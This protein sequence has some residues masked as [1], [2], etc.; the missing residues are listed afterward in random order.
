MF[1]KPTIW[2]SIYTSLH[3]LSSL[4]A[5]CLIPPCCHFC[6]VAP[7]CCPSQLH[8]RTLLPLSHPSSPLLPSSFLSTALPVALQISGGRPCQAFQLFK[9][10]NQRV[11]ARVALPLWCP[12]LSATRRQKPASQNCPGLCFSVFKMRFKT[13]LFMMPCHMTS[14]GGS[15]LI[16]PCGCGGTERAKCYNGWLCPWTAAIQVKAKKLYWFHLLNPLQSFRIDVPSMHEG[17]KE[18]HLFNT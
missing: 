18:R 9:Q 11:P 16:K 10:V 8:Q 4:P 6:T 12:T 3:L 15:L 17:K 2:S 5:A 13:R 1:T 14:G 7:Y